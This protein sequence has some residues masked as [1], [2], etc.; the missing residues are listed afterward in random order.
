MDSREYLRQ[1]VIQTYMHWVPDYRSNI[2][3]CPWCNQPIRP[4]EGDLH[5]WLVKRSGVSPHDFERINVPENLILVHHK[6]HIA[7]GQTRKMFEFC[8]QMAMSSYSLEALTDFYNSLEDIG[9]QPVE[10]ILDL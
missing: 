8:R 4:G 5:H 1:R 10:S 2:I 7:Y 6:C 9:L 3:I